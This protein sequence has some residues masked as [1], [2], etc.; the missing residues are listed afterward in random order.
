MTTAAPITAA[1][2]TVLAT[3]VQTARRR[4]RCSRADRARRTSASTTSGDGVASADRAVWSS[5]R[6][7]SIMSMSSLD[8]G[9]AVQRGPQLRQPTGGLALDGALAAAQGIGGFGHADVGHMP[10]NDGG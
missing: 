8:G 9:V 5:S 3:D 4:R 1:T 10:E 2:A 6:S 7:M